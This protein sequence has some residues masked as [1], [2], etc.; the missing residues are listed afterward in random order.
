MSKYTDERR[1]A[2]REEDWDGVIK[3]GELELRQDPNDIRVMNDLV[4]AHYNKKDYDR[5]FATCESILKISPVEDIAAQVEKLGPRYLRYYEVLGELYYRQNKHEEAL[6]VFNDLKPLGQFFSKKY[7][8]SAEIYVNRNNLEAAA[9][10]YEGMA[11]NC[12]RHASYATNA[13]FELVDVD[14]L[15]EAIYRSLFKVYQSLK[16]LHSMISTFEAVRKTGKATD[17]FIFTLVHLYLF[18]GEQDKASSIVKEELE[19]RP[20]NPCL[21]IFQAK[22]FWDKGDIS[23]AEACIKKAISLDSQNEARYRA[24]HD[25]L[26]NR[27]QEDE[28]KLK[29]TVSN[30]LK[31][32]RFTEAILACEQLLRM[33][34]NSRDC[35]LVMFEVLEKSI[36]N[37]LDAGKID[38]A[39]ELI[40]RLARFEKVDPSISKR[41]D[42]F[43]KQIS[44][45]RIDVYENM[46]ACGKVAGDEL[47]RIRLDLARAYEEQKKEPGR[48]NSLLEEI[49]QSGGAY[50]NEA[51]FRL[52]FHLLSAKKLEAAEAHIKKLST[53]SCSGDLMKSRFYDLGVACQEAGLK[54]QA[55]SLFG[56][57]LSTD[58]KYNDTAQ[59]MEELKAPSSGKEIPEAVM[60]VDIC[61]SSRMMDLFGDEATY[62]IKNAL[63]GIM[64]PIFKSC[65][66][67]FMKSTGDGFLVSFPH[68]RQAVDAAVEILQ[69]TQNYNSKITDG[70]E[71]HLRFGIHF[72]AVRLRP[73][74]DRHG[75][76]VNIPFR[77]EGLQVKDLIEVDEGISVHDF[78]VRDRILVTEAVAHGIKTDEKYDVRY[79]GLFELKN[80]TGIH[81]IFQIRT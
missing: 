50:E 69:R 43:N 55:R 35:Q 57:I 12:P 65:D 46:I 19:R 63:E 40:G 3:Y 75:T 81:K 73:D 17:R 22:I 8:L 32:E 41:V 54:H 33:R 78:P 18:T 64:F 2:Y 20:D 45:R 51:R 37:Y 67:H 58:P 39:I 52:A 34:P 24:I 9:K 13:L 42:I 56:E 49:I 59:R 70:P 68:T 74:G 79:I 10:E 26:L 15:N 14:P 80:I 31:N 5:A 38:Q 16:Q 47:N 62:Q 23:N 60:V 29:E 36:A 28:Q 71:I 11:E 44:D 27:Q 1:R 6:K 77:V 76:N 30:N 53:T 21:Q 25:D 7:S 61:E 72:G 66:S 4:H 48:A